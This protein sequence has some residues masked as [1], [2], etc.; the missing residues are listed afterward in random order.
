MEIIATLQVLT[1]IF[2][3]AS[4]GL[5]SHAK[6]G[7]YAGTLLTGQQCSNRGLTSEINSTAE[8]SYL[9]NRSYLDD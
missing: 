2:S 5:K 6:T 8:I 1:N 9:Q 3:R 4:T 7:D